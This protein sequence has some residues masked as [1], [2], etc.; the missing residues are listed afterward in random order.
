MMCWPLAN[1]YLLLSVKTESKSSSEVTDVFQYTLT[2]LLAEEDKWGKGD[3]LK[4]E[5]QLAWGR[6][7]QYLENHIVQF[8]KTSSFL[9]P[10]CSHPRPDITQSWAFH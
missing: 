10:H 9:Q 2:I 7:G 6:G 4:N 5:L 8:W 3:W 1:H